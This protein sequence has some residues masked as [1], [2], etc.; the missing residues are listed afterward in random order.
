[1]E[2][3][4]RHL[5]TVGGTALAAGLPLSNVHS[6]PLAGRQ[7][8]NKSGQLRML[9]QRILKAYAQLG[10][11]VMPKESTVILSRSVAAVNANLIDLRGA[12]TA[13][14]IKA[15]L[16][17]VDKAWAA[18]R[19][20]V[21]AAPN[22]G[23][24][25]AVAKL[26]DAMLT[27]ADTMTGQFE[28]ALGTEVG[29]IVGLAGRQRMLAQKAA[30]YYFFAAWG[31]ADTADKPTFDKTRTEF[32]TAL[33]NLKAFPQNSAEIKNRITM[34]DE[35]WTFMVVAFNS[36]KMGIYSP[37]AARNVAMASENILAI[38]DELTGLYENLKL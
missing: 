25:T 32:S 8:I 24:A 6:A 23:D 36:E 26:G 34:L 28:G 1:M 20:P 18:L 10:L 14:A 35:Q 4:R 12:A 15:S 38:A 22:K 16:A 2:I 7:A 29:K 21:A 13:D 17:A 3:T 30:R 11:G 5:L 9:S 37:A 27:E 31:V 19:D 33:A